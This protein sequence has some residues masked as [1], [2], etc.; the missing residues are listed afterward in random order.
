M[1]L[2]RTRAATA[3]LALSAALAWPVATATAATAVAA[4]PP[5]APVEVAV[6]PFAG[7]RD[8]QEVT[9]SVRST[10][11]VQLNQVTA[12]QCAERVTNN[13]DF[14]VVGARCAREPLSPAHEFEKPTGAF[15]S[16]TTSAELKYR[17]GTG[18][19]ELTDLFTGQVRPL[20]CGEG[21]HPCVIG[22]WIQQTVTAET[23][24]TVPIY[25]GD[26]KPPAGADGRAAADRDGH[27]AAPGPIPASAPAAGAPGA[28]GGGAA[29]SA[30]PGQEGAAPGDVTAGDEARA[31]AI[32]PGAPGGPRSL[33]GPSP[34]TVVAVVLAVLA[35]GAGAVV[36]LRVRN[37]PDAGEA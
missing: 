5:P 17:V 16:G 29:E 18:Q 12:N 15:P 37:R 21:Q 8:G 24:L 35:L 4:E 27:P 1:N 34:V 20:H 25:F 22:L 6:A 19:Q 11:G 26:D 7:L 28:S 23:F 3:L 2:H 36:V 10:N 30:G 31:P 13:F 9:I 32:D 33:A 14:S